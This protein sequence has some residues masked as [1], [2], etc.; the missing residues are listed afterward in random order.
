MCPLYLHNT[1]D[2]D[3]KNK[4]DS[5]KSMD[6]NIDLTRGRPASDQLDLSDEMLSIVPPSHTE[7]GIDIRNYGHPLGIKQARVLASSL[8][9]SEYETTAVC[10]QSSLLICYQTVLAMYLMGKPKAWKDINKPSFICP[11]PGF[12]RHFRILEDF[13]IDTICVPFQ[14]DGIDLIALERALKSERNVVGGIFVPRHSNPTGHTYS[15]SNIKQLLALFKQHAKDSIC[16][17]DHAYMFHDFDTTIKQSSLWGLAVDAG[18]ED[19][20]IIMSS[21]SK[22]TFGGGGISYFT[23]GKQLFDMVINQRGGMMVCPDKINQMRHCMFF[24]DKEALLGHM[25]QHAAI[26]KPKFDLVINMLENLDPKL[27]SFSKPTGGYFVSFDTAKGLAKRTV[28]ICKELGLLLTPA[29]STYPNF[30]DPNDSNI[31]LAPTAATIKEIK[32]S[33][34][35]F[36]VALTIAYLEAN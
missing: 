30:D 34:Q 31:R 35:I 13:E 16:I 9:G 14:E 10:E 23:A 32:T 28:S 33:M 12:D 19:K 4:Y 1:M 25:D 3:L 5:L 8:L 11:T 6:L 20:T 27:G 36:E 2:E 15:D 22:I 26:L 24:N 18:M 29:G 21:F 17:F 7:E